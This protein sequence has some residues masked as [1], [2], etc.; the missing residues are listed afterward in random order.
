MPHV[1]NWINN[2]YELFQTK[3]A[4]NILKHNHPDE[5]EDIKKILH[6]FRLYNSDFTGPGGSLSL[7]TRRLSYPFKSLNWVEEISGKSTYTIEMLHKAGT[8]KET[9][10]H[11]NSSTG[12]THK[13]DFYKN[14]V[15]LE[16]QW[17]S[18]DGVYSRDFAAFNMLY[19]AEAVDVAIF[20]TRSSSLKR[21]FSS[22]SLDKFGESSTHTD[23]LKSSLA[24]S[25]ISCPILVFGITD[26]LYE[27][28]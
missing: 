13:I 1:E 3:G 25:I 24:G 9:I 7:V 6:E 11:T 23:K 21:L 14:N 26:N 15:G 27:H 4:Y 19:Q 16:I 28:M 22:L 18:K 2:N 20:I 10:I 8:K 12:S 5:W 17:N